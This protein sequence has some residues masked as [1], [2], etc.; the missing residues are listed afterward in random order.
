M[1]RAPL[2]SLTLSLKWNNGLSWRKRSE[3]P[4]ASSFCP[5]RV[6]HG[7]PRAKASAES[8]CLLGIRHHSQSV[9]L[10]L[11]SFFLSSQCSQLLG[12]IMLCTHL[13]WAQAQ[14]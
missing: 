7:F 3:Q 4:S 5:Y 9:S 6:I 11:Q 1:L 10:Y 12:S 2:C 14:T 13:A 8:Q